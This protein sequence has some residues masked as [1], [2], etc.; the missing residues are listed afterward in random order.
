MAV[1]Q[2]RGN[3]TPTI[4]LAGKRGFIIGVANDQSIAYGCARAM[5]SLGADLAITYLNSHAEPYVRPGRGRPTG[6]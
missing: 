2:A 5:R 3:M 1:N 6:I 4:S